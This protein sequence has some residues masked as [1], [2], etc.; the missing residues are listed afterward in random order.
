MSSDY[1]RLDKFYEKVE[2]YTQKF[3]VLSAK[4]LNFIKNLTPGA[5]E[6]EKPTQ[7]F[8]LLLNFT[9]INYLRDIFLNNLE[10]KSDI[11]LKKYKLSIPNNTM[12]P[13]KSS[14]PKDN[15]FFSFILSSIN[16]YLSCFEDNL[17]NFITNFLT[18]RDKYDLFEELKM[19]YLKNLVSFLHTLL[20]NK[21]INKYF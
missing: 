19:I 14:L 20:Y 8:V 7:F 3:T 16:N 9:C 6:I 11:V 10:V 17:E 2:T 1:K 21:Y 4:F 13:T 12:Y 5:L 15:K 18:I